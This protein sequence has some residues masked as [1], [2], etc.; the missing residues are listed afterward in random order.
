MRYMNKTDMNRVNPSRLTLTA[1]SVVSVTG[2]LTV[3]PAQAE[4][5][6][7]DVTFHG[8]LVEAP[9][10]L[11]NG[12]KPVVIDFGNEVMTTRIDG[13]EYKKPVIFTPDCSEALSP[14]LKVRISGTPADFDPLAL[15]GGVQSGFGIAL[16][17]GSQRYA[18]GGW[19]P[20]T[21][22]DLPELYAVPVK[23]D[24]VTLSGGAFSIM[25]SM[26]VDYQ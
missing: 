24:G 20:F 25:A 10:C 21:V 19:L 6:E 12:G 17:R 16:Y 3:G 23:Q 26:V 13:K 22:P 9:P 5:M 1:L 11:V 18:P 8:T 2:L 4:G 15:A 14:K 7:A